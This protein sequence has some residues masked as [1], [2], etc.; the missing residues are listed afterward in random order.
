MPG[1]N[2]PHLFDLGTSWY[3][4]LV[5]TQ[6]IDKADVLL[7]ISVFTDLVC[8]LL[9][10]P[11]LWSVQLSPRKKIAVGVLMVWGAV[12]VLNSCLCG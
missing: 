8:S 7:A 1:F 3:V 11:I 2:F 4:S 10:F 9:P 6:A 5:K 12:Y